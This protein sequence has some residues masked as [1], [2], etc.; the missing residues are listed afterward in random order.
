MHP[1]RRAT[2]VGAV[3]E[4]LDRQRVHIRSQCETPIGDIRTATYHCHD[5]GT[6]YTFAELDTRC[7][8]LIR[9][10][11]GSS[12]LS[13]ARLGMCMKMAPEPDE[14]LPRSPRSCKHLVD[15]LL[16]MSLIAATS[17][18]APKTRFTVTSG[19]DS[20]QRLPR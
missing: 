11:S 7:A 19:S 16:K 2:D 17:M 8:E 14:L 18:I 15:H 12:V 20:D 4:L 9:Q 5:T 10:K 3:T 13:E 1:P 6:G